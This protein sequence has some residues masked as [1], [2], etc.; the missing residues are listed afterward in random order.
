MQRTQNIQNNFETEE[1]KE[2]LY[3]KEDFKAFSKAT[4]IVAIC[5]WHRVD[6]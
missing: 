5:Y 2:D 3:L 6:T 1:Q 4:V